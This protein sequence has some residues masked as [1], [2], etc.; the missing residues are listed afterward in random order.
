MTYQPAPVQLVARQGYSGTD[1]ILDFA[2]NLGKAAVN[3]FGQQKQAEGAAQAYASMQPQPSG[4]PGWVA[5][6]ALVGV[7][8]LAFVVL[9]PKRRKNPARGRR[10]R[11]RRRR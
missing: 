8:A 1:G 9:R 5:P 10:R 11:V 6:V 7:A 2:K 4:M 3:V